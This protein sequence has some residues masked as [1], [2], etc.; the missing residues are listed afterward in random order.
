MAFRISSLSPRLAGRR[1]KRRIASLSRREQGVA[2]IEFAL[3]APVMITMYLGMV[4]LSLAVGH[5]RKNTLVARTIADLVTQYQSVSDTDMAAVFDSTAAILAPYEAKEVTLRV[6]SLRIDNNAKVWVVWSNTK[7]LARTSGSFPAL[8][9]CADG[10][11]IVPAP[12]R[13]KGM[14]IVVAESKVQHTPVVGQYVGTFDMEETAYFRPRL[15]TEVA[16]DGVSTGLCPGEVP[17]S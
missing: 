8:T 16:R 17:V 11:S 2:L 3:V 9:R 1:L 4:E 14:S 6:T 10:Q 7:D 12:L 5:D 13:T 15:S